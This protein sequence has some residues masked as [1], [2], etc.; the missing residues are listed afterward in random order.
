MRL[1][2]LQCG[3]CEIAWNE[4]IPST[5]RTGLTSI[6]IPALLVET[7]DARYLVDTGM[8]DSL[9]DNTGP[10]A[11]GVEI[12]PRMKSADSI[13][14]QLRLLGLATRDITRVINTHL[15]FDHAGGNAHFVHQP[16]LIQEAALDAARA[17][18]AAGWPGWD[19][20]GLRY[21]TIRGDY[22]VCDGLDLLLT[23]GHTPGHQSVLVSLD[24]G[25]RLLFSGDAVYTGTNWTEDALGAMVDPV[26]GRA[27]VER[28]RRE[29]A[30]PST[31]LIFGH[32][33]EQWATLRHPPDWYGS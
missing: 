12:F 5:G 3:T 32:D 20:P 29:A 18:G 1:Y 14:E 28:L 23:P 31:T 19:V 26:A 27:S 22:H 4:L 10:L 9:I 11:E 17:A 30:L 16:I 25:Q 21:E 24:D 2:L 6:P 7:A 8:P 13:I 33:A 15:H